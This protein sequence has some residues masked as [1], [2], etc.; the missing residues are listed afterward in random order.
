MTI[1]EAPITPQA[2]PVDQPPIYFAGG[3]GYDQDRNGR[4]SEYLAGLGREIVPVLPNPDVRNADTGFS[5]VMNGIAT[6]LPRRQAIR[7]VSK[8]SVERSAA[9]FQLA[10]SEELLTSLE[11]GGYE[12][13]DAIF[14]SADALN[15][16]IAVHTQPEKFNNVVLAYP[17]GIIKQPNPLKASG[18]VVKSVVRGRQVRH[19]A[20]AVVDNF[21]ALSTSVQEKGKPK[22][23]GGFVT[24]ASVA[25]SYHGPLLSEVRCEKDAP[26]ISLVLGLDDWMIRPE[27]VLESLNSSNDVDYILITDTPH[28]VNGRTDVMD[29][30][31]NLFPMMEQAKEARKAGSPV[32]PLADRLIFSESVSPEKREELRGLAAGV[33]ARTKIPT[34]TA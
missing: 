5:V 21:E 23:A 7:T 15:G 9:N 20:A 12:K 8:P 27:R 22:T 18:G 14:Q 31:M 10:R 1:T 26:G 6:Q 13:V 34:S 33:D 4:V 2:I 11:Q 17:A 19:K 24:A 3:F 28:G 32:E 25:L 29:E 16:L 30:I